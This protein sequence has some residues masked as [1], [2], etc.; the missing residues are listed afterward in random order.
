MKMF[1]MVL[2]SM[3]MISQSRWDK[4][5]GEIECV[6][7]DWMFVYENTS[8]TK[9][10]LDLVISVLKNNTP[11]QVVPDCCVKKAPNE[12]TVAAMNDGVILETDNV[13][14]DAKHFKVLGDKE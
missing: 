5:I 9:E 12:V 11:F 10:E 8:L 6:V 3:I 14:L 7:F 2:G 4:V 1:L 13:L